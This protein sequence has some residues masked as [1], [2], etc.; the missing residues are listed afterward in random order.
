MSS[1]K[2]NSPLISVVLP[3]YNGEKFVAQAIESILDQQHRPLQII[4]VNDGSTDQ[5]EKV[6]RQ[7][8]DYITYVEQENGGP[9]SARNRGLQEVNGEYITFIDQDDVWHPNKLKIQLLEFEKHKQL[10]IAIGFTIKMPFS[11]PDDLNSECIESKPRFELLLG[12]SLTKKSAFEIAGNFSKELLV[13][14]DTDWFIRARE[15]KLSISVHSDLVF[16][17]RLHENNFTKKN[18]RSKF[19]LRILKQAVDRKKTSDMNV[20]SSLA[21]PTDNEELIQIWDNINSRSL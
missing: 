1:A 2:K 15:N 13:G 21:K 20:I 9:P 10:H 8:K 4:V 17:H 3:V 14:D 19:V 7:Y 6:L 16:Y 11:S 18:D 12:S 5:S